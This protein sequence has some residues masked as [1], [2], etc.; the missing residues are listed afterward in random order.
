M[1]LSKIE[2]KV[3]YKNLKAEFK[4]AKGFFV[5]SGKITFAFMPTCKGM[6][7]ITWAICGPNDI[8]NSK[9][10]KY[11]ALKRWFSGITL[12]IQLT[13]DPLAYDA[14]DLLEATAMHL[15]SIIG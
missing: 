9:R 12:P 2:K 10:G 13:Y 6:A 15:G 5:K 11:E 8:F 14:P 4:K 7:E 3:D 1:K